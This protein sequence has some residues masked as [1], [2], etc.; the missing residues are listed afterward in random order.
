MLPDR[1]Y[2]SIFTIYNIFYVLY[3][4]AN[5]LSEGRLEEIG[6]FFNNKSHKLEY[7]NKIIKYIPKVQ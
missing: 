7:N 3:L 1:S 4:P 6:I 2:K 5:L